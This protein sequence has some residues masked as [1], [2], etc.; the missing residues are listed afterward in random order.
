MYYEHTTLSKRCA[1]C[2]FLAMVI[3]FSQKKNTYKGIDITEE[4]SQ[5]QTKHTDTGAA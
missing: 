3:L 2:Y 1:Q 5:E 4:K